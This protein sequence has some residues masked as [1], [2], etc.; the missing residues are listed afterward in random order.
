MVLIE[1]GDVTDMKRPKILSGKKK[2]WFCMASVFLLVVA[3]ALSIVSNAMAATGSFDRES[4]LPPKNNTNDFDRA[5][6]SVTD[7]SVTSGDRDT[8]TVTAKAG[9]NSI[10]FVLRET[11]ATT[12]VFTTSG[13]AQPTQTGIGTSTGYVEAY[14]GSYV[15]PAFG[16]LNSASGVTGLNLKSLGNQGGNATTSEDGILQVSEGDTLALLYGGTTLDTAS[17]SYHGAPNSTITFTTGAGWGDNWPDNGTI[18]E[19]VI[20]NV[21]DP[22]KNLNPRIKDVIGLQDGFTLGLTGTATSRVEIEAIDPS[23]GN[24]LDDVFTQNIFLVETG[25][26]T[27][28]FSASGKIYGSTTVTTQGNLTVG[29]TPDYSGSTITLG[30]SP[31]V[32]FR[33]IET[34]AA[35]G[36]LG[37]IK[38]GT[39]TG[40]SVSEALAFTAS[41]DFTGFG[42]SSLGPTR[43]V[44][45][46]T[47]TSAFGDLASSSSMGTTIG[48]LQ[49]L[50]DG[51]NFCL[52]QIT[53]LGTSTTTGTA[54]SEISGTATSISS[55]ILTGPRTNDTIRA[56]YLDELNSGGSLGTVTSSTVFGLTGETGVVSVD[57]TTVDIN[58]FLVITVVD[59]NL[60]STSSSR[61]SIASGSW[62]GTTTNSRGDRLSV[63]AYSRTGLSSIGSNTVSLS[64]PDGS[65]IGTQSVRISKSDNSLVW[66]IPTSGSGLTGSGF[67]SPL[68]LGSSTFSLGTESTSA[69]PLV[70]GQ[71]STA[72]SFLSTASTASF[73]ATTDA[74]DNTVEISPDGTSW[75]AVPIVETGANSSTFV[76]TIGFDGTAARVTTNTSTLNSTSIFADSTGTSTIIFQG[77]A[78]TDY[79]ALASVFGTGSVVRVS[80]GSFSD[81][82]EIT[83]VAS[84]RLT[85]TKM[86]NT[87]F[88]TPW[89]TFVQVIGN[90]MS[91]GRLDTVS[92]SELF[93]IGGF[94]GGTYRI[95]YNDALN[96]SGEYSGGAT[97]ATTASNVAFQTN[98][99]SLSV[100]PSG[101]VGLNSTIEVTLVDNDLNISVSTP[102]TTFNNTASITNV[103]EVG[104]GLPGTGTTANNSTFKNGFI[105]K[106][107]FASRAASVSGS[108]FSNTA[109]TVSLQLVETGANSGTFR[110]TF[111]LTNVTGS[112][113]DNAVSPPV[114]KVS[115]GDNITVFYN[116]SPNATT[117][118][119]LSSYTTV[120]VVGAGGVG[121]LNLSKQELFLNGDSAV[122]TLEDNDLNTTGGLDGAQVKITS[123]SDT[124]GFD[125]NLT[126]TTGNS[127]IFQGTFSTGASTNQ[128]ATPQVIR[129]VANGTVIATYND[130]SPLQD[131]TKEAST[132][133]FGAV[134]EFAAD[135]REQRGVREK[136]SGR[137]RLLI[138][139]QD[140][141]YRILPVNQIG[142]NPAPLVLRLEIEGADVLQRGIFEGATLQPEHS[143]VSIVGEEIQLD[144]AADETE[145]LKDN[146]KGGTKIEDV[147]R[148]LRD[149]RGTG[150]A[151][152][153]NTSL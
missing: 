110:G 28:I 92:G 134:L 48:G 11:G 51:S 64:H 30:T 3:F 5:F 7:S 54:G 18:P 42:T 12:T 136:R 114:L 25:L 66:V 143:H 93:R 56:S 43:V 141:P 65:A 61:E 72:D 70:R 58:D 148:L 82:R 17:V 95:R 88:Y 52:V 71:S 140:W 120:S 145:V 1:K 13:N 39:A 135:N 113:T 24:R 59:G 53:G 21:N 150:F 116:D 90:D 106:Q 67:G 49:K 123:S 22:D 36:R 127:G 124:T 29:S 146:P 137:L 47:N 4:Y 105:A 86:T 133:N 44:A 23:T 45:I 35:S 125:L 132:K 40:S 96:S 80:D 16:F 46:G 41:S 75:I 129:A 138:H 78:G 37:L 107:I 102:Q 76:G 15:F 63:K 99:G 38:I 151:A 84:D 142:R 10:A 50:I 112:S 91:T 85:V 109:N 14:E 122:V 9:S 101:T 69:I 153:G 27:G 8:I 111:K 119:N 118:N 131:V 130:A 19:N 68:S 89:K 121:S 128:N 57:N 83:G 77:T 100:S 87:G 149:N 144:A 115:N 147:V 62:N 117:E 152:E 126:E 94:T 139:R 26:N 55:F 32:S 81:I 104:L 34:N 74:V 73:T 2:S 98:T 103:N 20:I 31:F 6:I 79:P 108:D 97:L 60:N 33:V